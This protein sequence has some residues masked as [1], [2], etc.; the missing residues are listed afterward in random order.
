MV[1]GIPIVFMPSTDM[2]LDGPRGGDAGAT[3]KAA[4]GGS[5][6]GTETAPKL[7]DAGAGLAPTAVTAAGAVTGVLEAAIMFAG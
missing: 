5:A 6:R 7:I 3:E 1:W 4:L 2:L